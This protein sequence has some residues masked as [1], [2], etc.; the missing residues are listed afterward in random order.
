MAQAPQVQEKVRASHLLVKHQ[1]SRRL[2]SWKD[3]QGAA[4]KKRTVKEADEILL[5][6]LKQIN[7]S[8]DPAATFHALAAQ[9]SDCSSAN[10]DPAG[11]LG[12]F[13]FN[14]MQKPFSEATYKLEVGAIT[15]EVVHTAS[16]SHLIM[17]TK[18]MPQKVKASHL[19]VKHMK[20]RN[21]ISRNE[22]NDLD[23]SKIKKRTVDEADKMLMA[24]LSEINSAKDP[25][26]KFTELAAKHS[27]CSSHKRGGD[28][29]FFEFGRMQKPFSAAAFKLD[30]G[31][32]TQYVVHSDSGS[33]LIMRTG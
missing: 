2:A 15:Q 18:L 27:D 32:I 26:A 7:E 16:G 1:E 10:S 20:S 17:R 23:G 21:P 24:Y 30:I 31:E 22:N 9:H 25:A 33:H 14:E 29:G 4:I 12:N 11:D 13:A 8:N 6:Y 3:P 5:G 28:L 19:L